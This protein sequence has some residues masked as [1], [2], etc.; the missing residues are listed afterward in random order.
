MIH[1]GGV[2]GSDAEFLAMA[3]P[4]VEEGLRADEPV[5]AATT[6]ANIELLAE[7]L[8]SRADRLDYAETAYFGRR[9]PQRVAAFHRYWRHANSTNGGRHVRIIAEP[10]WSG[11]STRDVLAWKRMES[12]LNLVLAGTNIWMICPYDTRVVPPDVLGAAWRTHPECVLGERTASS[13]DYVD[14]HVFT[15]EC[16]T[17]PLPPPPAG[18][19]AVRLAGEPRGLREFLAGHAAVRDLPAGQEAL[20]ITAANEVFAYLTARGDGPAT[21]R[22]WSRADNLICEIDQSGATNGDPVLGLRPPGPEAADGEGLWLA[23]QICDH[24][25]VRATDAGLSIRLHMPNSR[26]AELLASVQAI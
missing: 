4:F 15:A 25:D 21:V 7:T 9:P 26:A 1:Q 20:F 16:D 13:A 19:S 18:A 23:R 24:M 11:R 8:G 5:L 12:S 17:V 6:A 2:Y 10:V 3:M 22:L 14:P